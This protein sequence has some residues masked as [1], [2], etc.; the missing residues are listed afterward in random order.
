[1]TT[2]PTEDHG[3]ITTPTR[4]HLLGAAV[5]GIA[6]AASALFLP[7]WLQEAAARVGHGGGALGGR[8]GTNRRGHGKHK[9]RDHDK[10][11][12][13]HQDQN[14]DKPRGTSGYRNVAVTVHNYRTVPV[15]VRGWVYGH[16]S[17]D[18]AI[19]E[20]QGESST[21]PARA[22]DGSHASRRLEFDQQQAIVGIETQRETNLIYVKNP[23]LG[24]PYASILSDWMTPRGQPF[25]RT[26][27]SGSL[28][29]WSSISAEGVKVTR[30]P[31]GDYIEFSV[32]L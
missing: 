27:A 10:Q 31:D 13:K 5:G 23:D 28:T 21:L 14:Q 32:D 15:S 9:R 18:G 2:G 12:D 25:G 6:L 1:M 8:H 3:K 19:Y 30:V 7:D 20:S 11:K 24:F 17:R 4:R 22:A 29:V 26:L 16:D